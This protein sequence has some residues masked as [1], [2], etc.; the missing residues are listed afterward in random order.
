MWIMV[1]LVGMV[2]VLARAMSVEAVC[3]VNDAAALQADAI[4]QGAVQYVLAHVDSLGGPMPS[5]LDMPCEGVPIGKGGFWIIRPNFDDP[6]LPAYGL[7]GESAKL[8]INS[9]PETLLALLPGST[10]NIACSI[11][12]WRAAAKAT[13]TMSPDGGI[14]AQSE[15]YLLADSPYQCKN[16]P[17]ETVE[18]LLLVKEMTTDI[19]YG[20]DTSHSGFLP[21]GRD[22]GA[23]GVLDRGMAPFVTACS[24]EPNAGTFTPTGGTG[25]VNVN[26]DRK[27]LTDLITAQ[28]GGGAQAVIRQITGGYTSVL[29][30]YAKTPA[31]TA[32]QFAQI[33]PL[34]TTQTRAVKGLVNI[35]TAPAEVLQCF[36]NLAAGRGS[37]PLTDDDVAALVN[38]RAQGGIDANNLAWVAQ[39]I[40]DRNKLAAIGRYLTAST[41]QFSAD[42]VSVA[43]NGRAFRR[44]RVI[45][46]ATVT[47]PKIIYR[48]NLTQLG[49]PLP[50]DILTTLRA[51]KGLD[52]AVAAGRSQTLTLGQK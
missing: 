27:K 32:Q 20:S 25:L 37:I 45:V 17:F 8:N 22:V 29:D 16:A 34:I 30:F 18:E 49:W 42:I 28:L 21:A 15:Y 52:Q 13:P 33:A 51:G 36:T 44:C 40:T 35:S 31:L 10:P 41:Y 26:G 47:P 9:A 48:Q 43:G 5:D 39:V 7:V 14:G 1:V 23:T 24:A 11:V 38:Q 3:S 2:L 4:E 6:R 46:D 19:L 12:D 50:E